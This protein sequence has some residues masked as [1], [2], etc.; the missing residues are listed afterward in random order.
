[1]NKLRTNHMVFANMFLAE[2]EK[3]CLTW[4][5]YT[6]LLTPLQQLVRWCDSLKRGGVTFMLRVF[7]LRTCSCNGRSVCK[8]ERND[9]KATLPRV[10]D[11]YRWARYMVLFPY[12]WHSYPP[13]GDLG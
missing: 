1:M 4:E 8:F 11:W 5:K 6:T 12:A 2:R 13:V 7:D 9:R 3:N 10:R